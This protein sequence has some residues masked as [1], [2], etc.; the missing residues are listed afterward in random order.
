MPA[1]AW[2]DCKKTAENLSR[3]RRRRRRYQ[4][5]CLTG[6]HWLSD[7]TDDNQVALM[8]LAI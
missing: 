3:R 8:A 5:H 6:S 1:F 2:K 4:T 7:T